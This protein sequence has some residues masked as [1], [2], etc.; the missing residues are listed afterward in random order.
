MAVE[1]P[2]YIQEKF[3]KLKFSEFVSL[4]P[5]VETPCTP[6]TPDTPLLPP[7]E[8]FQLRV[9]KKEESEKV[10]DFLRTFFFRDEPLNVDVKLL[11][12]EKTC[13]ELEEYSMKALKDNVSVMAITDSG[14]IIGVCLNG[15]INKNDGKEEFIVKDPKFSKITNLLSYVDKMADVF[16]KY[17][18]IDKMISVDILS[19]DKSW[20]G[21]GIA[22]K[23][24]NKTRELAR[25]Q[26][27]KLMRCDCSSH[28]SA[29]A[30]A[31]LG[32]QCIYSLKYEDYKKEGRPVF[33]PEHPH[34]EVTVYIQRIN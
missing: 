26:D 4:P 6:Q 32:F 9:I 28:F 29:K 11:D 21:Q 12:G 16:G 13:K 2:S 18:D 30:I 20:R 22:K 34:K 23:L 10:L 1:M 25:E 31:R 33:N 17:P 3:T 27:F 14:K 8:P 5:S 15:I 19:V 24:M 7:P